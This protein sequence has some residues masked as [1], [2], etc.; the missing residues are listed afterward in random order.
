MGLFVGLGY[1][2]KGSFRGWA[3]LGG[4][5]LLVGSSWEGRSRLWG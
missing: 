2:G 1:E 4:K 5:G 3:V